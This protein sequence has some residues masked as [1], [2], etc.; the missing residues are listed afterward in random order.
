MNIILFAL[1]IDQRL[2]D[3]G[4]QNVINKSSLNL[5]TFGMVLPIRMMNL[6]LI[7]FH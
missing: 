2:F 6:C 3:L 5:M 4:A 1:Q 7:I